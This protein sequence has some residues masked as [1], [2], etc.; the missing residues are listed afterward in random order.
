MGTFLSPLGIAF[1]FLIFPYAFAASYV[2]SK[3]LTCKDH[4]AYTTSLK[5]V[6]VRSWYI[7][8]FSTNPSQTAYFPRFR[9]MTFA[10]ATNPSST[11]YKTLDF[12]FTAG[13]NKNP[14]WRMYFQRAAKVHIIVPVDPAK[15][16][17]SKSATLP[18]G[19]KSEGWVK[20]VAGSSTLTYGIHQRQKFSMKLHYYMFSKA[21][22]RK[23]TDNFVDFPQG[24]YLQM[25]LKNI[26]VDGSFHLLISEANGTPSKP[27]GAF[28]GTTI[29]PNTKCPSAL[30]DVWKT[31]DNDDPDTRGVKFRTWHPNWDPC[32]WW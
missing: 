14:S 17:L 4:P 22:T 23:G 32:Y 31:T 25:Q 10:P 12:F 26:G 8:R 13:Q 27:V 28:K 2:E 30:H 19:W 9:D 20:R 21:T 6:L 24:T 3:G 15:V 16:D 11:V 1:I 18:G 7:Y 5:P 29:K